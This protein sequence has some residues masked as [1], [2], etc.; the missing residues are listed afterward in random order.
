MAIQGG[1]MPT[2]QKAPM[3][4]RLPD[5]LKAWVKSQAE[6]NMRSVNAEIVSLLLKEKKISEGVSRHD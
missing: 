1:Q 3:P 4:V 5:D 2:K 6:A